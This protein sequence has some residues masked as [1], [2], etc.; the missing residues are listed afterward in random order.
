[1]MVIVTITPLTLVI[2][3]GLLSRQISLFW[4]MN[5]ISP[6]KYIFLSQQ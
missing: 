4:E 2:L 3:L 6:V 1:M 5:K